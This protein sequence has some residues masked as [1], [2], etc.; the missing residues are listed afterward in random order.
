M[1]GERSDQLPTQ[2][3][4]LFAGALGRA[5][6]KEPS[7]ATHLFLGIFAFAF[8]PALFPFPGSPFPAP[9]L[10][11]PVSWFPEPLASRGAWKHGSELRTTSGEAGYSEGKGVYA[12]TK[13]GA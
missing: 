5:G 12:R 11:F 2:T 10:S 6:R 9:F 1:S 13:A 4:A 8:P 3:T 7:A